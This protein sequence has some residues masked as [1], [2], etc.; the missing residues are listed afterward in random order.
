MKRMFFAL[1]TGLLLAAPVSAQITLP[2]VNTGS[3]TAASQCV[4]V[5]TDGY[6]A[7]GIQVTGSYVGTITWTVSIDGTNFVALDAFTPDAPGTAA[8]STTTTGI[9]TAPIAGLRLLK[10]CMTAYTSGTAVVTVVA[11]GSGG[12]GGGGSGGGGGGEVTN[13]GTF[14]VQTT[15][16]ALPTDA[17]IASKQPALGT[18]G[19][20]SADVISV[21]G[22][23]G[24]KPLEVNLTDASGTPLSLA[25][26]AVHDAAA[27]TS[28]PQL[29]GECDDVSTDAVDE[30]DA[31]KL[32]V[33]CTS[34]ELLVRES[35]DGVSGFRRTSAGST[36]DE[37][38]I[39]A[40]AGVLYSITITNTNAAARYLRCSNKTAANTTPGSETP[41]IDLA[42]PGNTAGA[43]FTTSFPKG[44]A[45]STALTCWMVTGAA[46]TDVA[47]V[48]ANEIKAFYTF[49]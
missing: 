35:A 28:G 40:T 49:R 3:L 41:I 44:F 45:F 33:H 17:S 48:A 5:R 30:G 9:W 36:E 23:A 12:G 25:G 18:F 47:E 19:T 20:A 7:G 38:E 39:K 15:V 22:D 34:R 43:G 14:A 13:A 27:A 31:A 1:I 4:P 42:I 37:H 16:T 24:M 8:N 46:D 6:G 21:Q 29:I 26:D 10:A 11:S 2:A 32:R